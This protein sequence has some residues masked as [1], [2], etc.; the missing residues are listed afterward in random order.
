M[1]VIRFS[2]E[3][4]EFLANWPEVHRGYLSGGDG[5]IF[6]TRIEVEDRQVLCRRSSSESCHF[7]VAFPIPGR[8]PV[9]I[10][11][12]TLPERDQ[13]YL[14]SVELAR[15]LIVQLRNQSSTWQ[16][17]GMLVPDEFTNRLLEAQRLFAK[18]ALSQHD[19]G[20]AWDLALRALEVGLDAADWLADAFRQ[21]ALAG[22]QRSFATMPVLLGCELN[23]SEVPFS[24]QAEFQ[25]VF[26][27]AAVRV[28]WRDVESAEGEYDWSTADRHLEYC[29]SHRLTTRAGSLIDLGAG[30]LPDWLTPW[31]HDFFN[32][33]SFVC[34]FVETA[35]SRYVGRVRLWE[36]AA[37]FNTGGVLSL[38]EESRL[39]LVARVLDTARQVDGESQYLVR[40]DQPWGEYQARGQHRLTPLQAID[41]LAR[42][43]VGLGGVNLEI[44]VG[45]LPC[46][47][48]NRHALDF[49][50]MI[51]MWSLLGLPL[52]VTLAYPSRADLDMQVSGD[53]EVDSRISPANFGETEQAT[54]IDEVVPLLLAK[55]SV[56]GVFWSHFTDERAHRFPNAGLWQEPG[57]AKL[58]LKHLAAW[59][60]ARRR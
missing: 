37:R 48:A 5:R 44:A 32:L 54:W 30:G 39:S 16:L 57:G 51:D 1:G 52:Y 11:T 31:E 33:Q 49:C 20:L 21:Q 58:G 18:A 46:G 53:T 9:V 14:L 6:A 13:P 3:S 27:A 22:R 25:Q 24:G 7:H 42:S 45:F 56:A 36:V 60:Q 34:D 59:S 23:V 19:E 35:I 40:V 50:R 28:D 15:G 47:T 17:A 26:N 12:T 10:A 43:G 8:G 38:N 29:E 55:P 41:A 2:V 4:A